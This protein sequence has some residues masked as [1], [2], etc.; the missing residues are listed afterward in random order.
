MGFL[1]FQGD[2]GY[3]DI[4]EHTGG[5]SVMEFVMAILDNSRDTSEVGRS[6]IAY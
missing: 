2:Q 4:R 5:G 3:Q 1:D 6:T